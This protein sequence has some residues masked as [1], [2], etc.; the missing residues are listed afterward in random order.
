MNKS[1]TY[2]TITVGTLKYIY[3]LLII[4]VII[5][6][7]LYSFY[8]TYD[9]CT[10]YEYRKIMFSNYSRVLYECTKYH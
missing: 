4:I 8:C 10:R 9:N 5:I 7:T 2:Y 6:I 1:E 3:E